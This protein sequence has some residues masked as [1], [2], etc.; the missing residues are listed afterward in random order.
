MRKLFAR[1][2]KSVV[3]DNGHIQLRD[4]CIRANK[5][6]FFALGERVHPESYD[7]ND[8]DINPSDCFFGGRRVELAVMLS[9][10]KKAADKDP[11][12]PVGPDDGNEPGSP[13]GE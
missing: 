8:T 10:A 9:D 5:T 4:A 12:K 2:S 3:Q 1:N 7:G 13:S 6:G 11:G